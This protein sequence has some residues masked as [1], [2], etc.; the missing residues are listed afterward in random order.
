MSEKMDITL[1]DRVKRLYQRAFGGGHLI[2]D[3][4]AFQAR[5]TE[6]CAALPP[7]TWD[8]P[9]F[10]PIGNGLCRMHLRPLLRT[11]LS[12]ETAAAMC[13]YSASHFVVEAYSFLPMLEA[14]AETDADREWLAAYR[15]DNMPLVGHSKAY[16]DAYR[17]AYRV[18]LTTFADAFAL[19]QWID[20]MPQGLI[21][22]DGPC[23]SGKSTLAA[24]LGAVFGAGVLHMDDFFLRPEQR[25]AQ[26][27]AE[28][29]GNVDRERFAAEVLTPLRAGK[30]FAY[31]PYDCSVQAL[32]AP[33]AFL[34]TPR[35]IVEGAYSM[36]PELRDAYALSAYVTV[37]PVE[38]RARLLER[39][40]P[41]MLQRFETE[42]I[43]M[44]Q[45][46]FDAYQ[47]ADACDIRLSF[48]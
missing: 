16:R 48:A 33:V 13:V 45:A 20:A 6:E 42:W 11:G 26:R 47:V 1:Q 9:L 10:E 17:P 34:M 3:P 40:G 19:M 37:D 44:E 2:R 31:R 41:E 46:Y 43:P 27:L 32:S 38:Q 39:N 18:V 4:A 8:E 21:A 23:A 29:G 36:H 5:L 24:A 30:D 35:V 7:A 12:L 14:L 22:I 28:P 15:A 25:T